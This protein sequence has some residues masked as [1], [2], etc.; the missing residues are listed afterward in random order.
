[1]TISK[2]ELLVIYIQHTILVTYQFYQ[3]TRV[4]CVL[5]SI[6]LLPIKANCLGEVKCYVGPTGKHFK[7]LNIFYIPSIL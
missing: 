3:N 4:S 7:F 6:I 5:F 2:N 1:M